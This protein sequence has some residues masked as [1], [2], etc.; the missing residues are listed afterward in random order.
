MEKLIYNSE[1]V[2]IYRFSW[3]D[4][5]G[6]FGAEVFIRAD[7]DEATRDLV[8]ELLVGLGFDTFD[9]EKEDLSEIDGREYY[10]YGAIGKGFFND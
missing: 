2:K 1:S 10:Q 7:I 9:C 5:E 6:T 4:E 3:N 8:D